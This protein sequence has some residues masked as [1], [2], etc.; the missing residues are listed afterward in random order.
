MGVGWPVFLLEALGEN[1]P[2]LYPVA[3]PWSLPPSSKPAP[4]SSVSTDWGLRQQAR[5]SPKLWRWEVPDEDIVGFISSVSSHLAG[6]SCFPLA[7]ERVGVTVPWAWG[8]P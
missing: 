8:P 2:L 7:V 6:D 3:S 1:V 4:V 5:T